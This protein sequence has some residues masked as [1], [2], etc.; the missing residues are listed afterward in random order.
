MNTLQEETNGWLQENS[1]SLLFLAVLLIGGGGIMWYL[2]RAAAASQQASWQ[3]YATFQQDLLTSDDEDALNAALAAVE[4][5]DRVYPWALAYAVQWA[6]QMQKDEATLGLL[7]NRLTSLPDGATNAKVLAAG[8]SVD[9][10][11]AVEARLAG[12][13]ALADLEA[14]PIAPTG[15]KIKITLTD[16]GGSTY[17]MVVQL[18][19]TEAPTATAWLLGQIDAGAF[20]EARP[21]PAAQGGFQIHG[22]TEPA[23]DAASLMVEKAWGC[24]HES[25]TL[26][27]VLESGGVPGEQSQTRLQMLGADLHSQDGVTTVLGMIVEGEDRLTAVSELSRDENN[28]QAFAGEVTMT[29]ERVTE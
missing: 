11:D 19:E 12:L 16:E 9:V 6:A 10:S 27:T 24:F 7:E 15:S 18:Y 26:C 5:D 28:P 13:R 3:K 23:E 8:T 1:R 4:G 21:V 20:A 22:L 14:E 29:I 25:G 17:D 2:P